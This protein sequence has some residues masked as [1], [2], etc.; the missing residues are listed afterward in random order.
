MG[1]KS[2][3]SLPFANY[4]VLKNKKWKYN[5]V[6]SQKKVFKNLIKSAKNTNFVKY[7]NF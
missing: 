5:A 2:F 1:V 3:L 4:V 6:I 7:N